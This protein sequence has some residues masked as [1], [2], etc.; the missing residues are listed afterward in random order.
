MNILG[1]IVSLITA[2][3]FFFLGF[4]LQKWLRVLNVKK[5]QDASQKLI[6]DAKKDA[7]RYRL[8]AE[9][10]FKTKWNKQRADFEKETRK[11]RAGIEKKEKHLDI[12]ESNLERRADLLT[13][14][15]AELSAKETNFLNEEKVITAKKGRLD[16]LILEENR[17]LEGIAGM[18]QEEAKQQL[19]QNLESKV[20]DEAKVFINEEV[21]KARASA[22]RE[23]KKIISTAIGR[24]ASEY[25][26]ESTVSQIQLPSD[27]MKG[28]VIGREGRN[29]RSFEALTGTNLIIDDTPGSIFLSCLDPTRREVAKISLER[30]IIDGRIHPTR[31]EEVVKRVEAEFPEAIRKVGEDVAFELKIS[32]LAPELIEL[33]G[34]L[35]FRTSYGQNVLAHSKEVAN[36]ASLMA[37]ELKLSAKEAKRAG[38][39]HDIGKSAPSEYEGTHQKIGGELARRYGESEIVVNAIE[40]HHGDID[41]ISPIAVLVEAADSIS[42][43][44]LGAR[45]ETFEAY[46]ERLEKLETVVS[47]FD[48]V[49]KAYAIQ[50]GREIRVIVEPNKISDETAFE[51]AQSLAKKIEHEMKYPGEIKVTVVRETRASATAK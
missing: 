21:Q 16:A 20:R 6:E 29:I 48:G 45:R 39:L 34:H 35:K 24:C 36:L 25:M 51:L 47:S 22:E 44:R 14:K 27:E 3:V 4:R 15:Q 18:T 9:L 5:T 8:S 10:E 2:G 23:A 1:Y 7:E 49:G 41:P 32:G 13:E 28:R 31:I 17:K 33:L 12:R 19:F 42:G 43:A 46:V 50:A 38:L 26:L 40:A 37:L 11:R 30:L